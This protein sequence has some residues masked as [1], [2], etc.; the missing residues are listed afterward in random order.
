MENLKFLNAVCTEKLRTTDG[1][2]RRTTYTSSAGARA[3]LFVHWVVFLV[4]LQKDF[5]IH[6]HC[7]LQTVHN[8]GSSVKDM[9]K[10]QKGL[11][12]LVYTTKNYPGLWGG[13]HIEKKNVVTQRPP[14]MFYKEKPIESFRGHGLDAPFFLGLKPF[15]DRVAI[16][17]ANGDFTYADLFNR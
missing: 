4:Q 2:E 10:G 7:R 15:K 13:G 12:T 14:G 8:T 6:S 1:H 17:A 5:K 3:R 11:R 16:K 9:D